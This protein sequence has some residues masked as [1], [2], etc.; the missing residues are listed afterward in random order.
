MHFRSSRWSSSNHMSAAGSPLSTI[1]PPSRS[2]T[3]YHSPNRPAFYSNVRLPRRPVIPVRPAL[4]LGLNRRELQIHRLGP[5]RLAPLLPQLPLV[6]RLLLQRRGIEG[7]DE[8]GPS[9]GVFLLPLPLLPHLPDMVQPPL[10]T[11]DRPSCGF[12]SLTA[13]SSRCTC[14][15]AS[16]RSG[17][18]PYRQWRTQTC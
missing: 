17:L 8:L 14:P 16:T 7:A 12:K 13:S 10:N 1:G 6:P 15:V 11:S 18:I 5:M 3:V 2:L 4:L 9:G